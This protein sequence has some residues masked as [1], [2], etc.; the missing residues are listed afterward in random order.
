MLRVTEDV[1]GGN[2]AR[3]ASMVQGFTAQSYFRLIEDDDD[4]ATQY[5]L[6]AREIWEAYQR[7]V[8]NDPR[9]MPP[10]L[11]EIK[12]EVLKQLLEEKTGL[13][14]EAADR[15]RKKLGLPAPATSPVPPKP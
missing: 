15:L 5:A 11:P 6:R 2:S 8:K 12:R 1:S 3:I 7:R 14:P 10:P 4:G 9:L 13:V